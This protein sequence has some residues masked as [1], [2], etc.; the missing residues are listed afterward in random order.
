VC[1]PEVGEEGGPD[2]PSG[3]ADAAR[4]PR[5]SPGPTRVL[6]VERAADPHAS[7][8]AR[9][10]PDR[11]GS[12]ARRCGVNAIEAGRADCPLPGDAGLLGEQ[13]GADVDMSTGH[14]PQGQRVAVDYQT[15]AVPPSARVEAPVCQLRA[16]RGREGA[17]E[18]EDLPVEFACSR[19]VQEAGPFVRGVAVY[20]ADGFFELRTTVQ[21]S[22]CATSTQAPDVL[23]A[24]ALNQVASASSSGVGE[25]G[26]MASSP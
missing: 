23:L 9:P 19:A 12:G 20:G 25:P 21:C 14:E 18:T 26:V 10:W 6:A 4:R 7:A 16:H 15:R 13:P 1:R 11:R 3:R 5:R 2:P 17:A 22:G 24:V 8:Q